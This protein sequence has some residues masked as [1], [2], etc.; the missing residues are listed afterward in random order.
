MLALL[1]RCIALE[2][3]AGEIY[4]Q[5][6]MRFGAD[7]ELHAVW[8]NMAADERNHARKLATWRT[9]VEA[10]PPE[11]RETASGFDAAIEALERLMESTRTAAARVRTAD[12]A[13]ALAL[14]LE[15]SEIDAV[16][17][18]LLQ[19]SPIARFPDAKETYH[20]ETAEHHVA[21]V[22]VV[23]ARSRNER[24]LLRAALLVAE[25]AEEDES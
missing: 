18:R 3:A 11:H 21:L 25:D 5:L 23:R 15:T 19:S 17:T 4:T 20:R 9:L 7:A 6:A 12:G 8:S 10:E 13:F 1:A 14:A 24:N 2:L 16:Y 22:R